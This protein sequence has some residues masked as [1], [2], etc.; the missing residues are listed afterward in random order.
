MPPL[1]AMALAPKGY[2][3]DPAPDPMGLAPKGFTLDPEGTPSAVPPPA[4]QPGGSLSRIGEEAGRAFEETRVL[5]P[6]WAE[7]HPWARTLVSPL[8]TGLGA[9]NALVTG[10]QQAA[11]E[12]GTALGQPQL[13]RD[14]A[15]LPEAFPQ[16]SMGLT[17]VIP[18]V[19]G[20]P[21]VPGAEA[22]AGAA[23][24][25]PLDLAPPGFTLDE[26][27]AA[28]PAPELAP[29]PAERGAVPIPPGAFADKAG[30]VRDRL[31][32]DL[33]LTPEQAAGIVGHLG[34]ESGLE[35]INE[36]HPLV[37]GS[38]GGFGWAQWTGP[39]R[40]DFENWARERNLDPA[41]DEANYGYLVH[42]LTINHPG[43][44]AALRGARNVTEAVQAFMPFEAPGKVAL[45]DR[46]AKAEQALGAGAGEWSA[47]KPGEQV[48]KV[49]TPAEAVEPSSRAAPM[50]PPPLP[51]VATA[52]SE[53]DRIAKGEPASAAPIPAQPEPLRETAPEA[54]APE[55]A[56]APVSE[57]NP[58]QVKALRQEL[59]IQEPA[60]SPAEQAGKATMAALEGQRESQLAYL[61]LRGVDTSG[62]P[63]PVRDAVD[64]GTL[65]PTDLERLVSQATERL[66]VEGAGPTTMQAAPHW[67]NGLDEGAKQAAFS[68]M[69]NLGQEMDR[70]YE[71][72]R[73]GQGVDVGGGGFDD[74]MPAEL[75]REFLLAVRSGATPEEAGAAAKAAAQEFVE[76]HNQRRPTDIN[77]QRSTRSYDLA[78]DRLAA[79]M[80]R[81]VP[82]PAGQP[83]I[84]QRAA[85][86][87]ELAVPGSAVQ[88]PRTP[89][90]GRPAPIAQPRPAT[91]PPSAIGRAAAAA[92]SLVAKPGAVRRFADS[93]EK[94][95][96]PT[97]RTAEA[98]QMA[99]IITEHNAARV[100][101]AERTA[102]QLDDAIYALDKLPDAERLEVWDRAEQGLPQATPILQA[103]VDG[104]RRVQDKWTRAVQGLSTGALDRLVDNYMGRAYRNYPE[105]KAALDGYEA[106]VGNVSG[107]LGLSG[108]VQG[109]ASFLKQ[110]IF[111]GTLR[112][113]MR[114]SEIPDPARPGETIHLEPITS[115]PIRMQVMKLLEMQQFYHGTR[116]LNEIKSSGLSKW[117]SASDRTAIARQ[118][119]EALNDKA[120][121]T[122]APPAA[123]EHFTVYDPGIRS[124]LARIA[125]KLGIEVKTPLAGAK[126]K[127]AAAGY[128][129]K[130][131][132]GARFGSNETVLM[133]EIGHQLDASFGLS[134]PMYGFPRDPAAW[135]ELG[136]LGRM[137]EPNPAAISAQRLAYVES[138]GER[139]AN[140]LHAYWH[141]PELLEQVAPQAAQLW[142]D[143]L[144]SNPK[145]RGLVDSVKPSVR[146]ESETVEQHF[147]GL[148]LMGGWYAPEQI[149][150]VFNNAATPSALGE[151]GAY[152]GFRAIENA[153]NSV[154]LGV[155]GF[156][157]T[158]IALDTINSKLA[159]G[160]QQL[161]RGELGRAA[162]TLARA[163]VAP[164]EAVAR[165]AAFRK[166]ALADTA[167]TPEMQ[168]LVRL[169]EQ[170]GGRLSMDRFYRVTEQGPILRNVKDV[171][172]LLTE[173]MGFARQIRDLYKEAPP[174]QATLSAAGRLFDTT[175][176]P[177][178]GVLV[179]RAKLGVMTDLMTDWLRRNPG[180]SDAEASTAMRKISDSVDN[181]MGEV[182]YDNI[183]WSKTKKDIG[184]LT[185]RSTGWNL[186]TLREIG[187][188]A[189]DLARLFNDWGHLRQ[190]E[191]TGRTAYS[192]AMLANT[193]ILGALMT[194]LYTGK[195]PQ[196]ALDYFY[197]PTGRLLPDGSM[198]RYSIPGY[199]KDVASISQHPV[200][201]VLNKLNPA[202]S[203][204]QQAYQ[205]R[206]YY[207]HIIYY[208]PKDN[209]VQAYG[210][211]LLGQ[212]EPFSVRNIFRTQ[213][214]G[215]DMLDA[216]LSFF[217]IQPAPSYISNPARQESFQAKRD[218]K[219]YQARTRF[220]NKRAAPQ[221][222]P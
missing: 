91:T 154:Q 69:R 80:R 47:P 45:G 44:L 10:G 41:S 170:G 128:S 110:R 221:H 150:T 65:S 149:A 12:A 19:R 4:V 147:P 1:D 64:S 35:G 195:G 215:G 182:V 152:R 56:R 133:H 106:N 143:M 208:A 207:G 185:F 14:I 137:R 141:A 26:P 180:A 53:L 5:T 155:S 71:R 76:D 153:L 161:M 213:E 169:F 216:A 33:G 99:G 48:A 136:Q 73:P 36:R 191:F 166:A 15:A 89:G 164:I 217:G 77:W 172:R 9:L 39:R 178:M 127:Q 25:H 17:G 156:H 211:W 62:L 59:G 135:D 167:A 85:A 103:A 68:H 3:L 189:V 165:G 175:M 123:A 18:R 131:E 90:P 115:N 107:G 220:E 28:A 159:L 203:L 23:V 116:M 210:S 187:G 214:S 81:A 21:R 42:D 32:A 60:V 163:P 112:D 111:D 30:A 46:V 201:T 6:E 86:A 51:D 102:H 205:N 119:W 198:E 212:A 95:W 177:V 218:L 37:P 157:A 113:A 120:F 79:G 192:I 87:P 74:V 97:T 40:V 29:V 176:H 104:L 61:A 206:D 83:A 109:R 52:A 63:K 125:A 200:Q 72:A 202:L 75:R 181:R 121:Q 148:R 122:W 183:F 101:D 179:P 78:A 158:F 144:A 94:A 188:G 140:L 124:G 50:P 100:R 84:P 22:P 34:H 67:L 20:V 66:E 54:V 88:R 209:M 38:R 70:S 27:V 96:S 194:Y 132:I 57:V 174:L 193:A 222:A 186:G 204:I 7:R 219:A 105:W 118:G 55:Q 11:V 114:W 8:A 134:S 160:L 31:Q 184:F 173:P 138:P 24:P 92:E 145:L 43:I 98:G 130:G 58:E 142:R 196:Q 126:L 108:T 93:I 82:E 151:S 49:Q 171:G 197:P 162:S 139:I 117:I 199:Y 16:E 13:G 146:M 190:A 2:T 168:R 129:E